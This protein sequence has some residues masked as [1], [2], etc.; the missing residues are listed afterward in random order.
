MPGRCSH[1]RGRGSTR[2]RHGAASFLNSLLEGF[3]C[4]PH[5]FEPSVPRFPLDDKWACIANRLER[6]EE[7]ARLYLAA[8]KGHFFAPF[9]TRL[10][11]ERAILDMHMMDMSAQGVYCLDWIAGTIQNHVGRIEI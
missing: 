3:D 2:L 5:I 10:F 11:G 4:K 8:A 6:G 1:Q 7:C 9:H